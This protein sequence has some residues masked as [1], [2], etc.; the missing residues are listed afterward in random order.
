MSDRDDES[1]MPADAD[2]AGEPADESAAQNPPA[3]PEP[4]A[5]AARR[6][7]EVEKE[8]DEYLDLARRARADYMNLQRR[9]ESQGRAIRDAAQYEFAKDVIVVLDDIE[10]AMKHTREGQ[11]CSAILEGLELVKRKFVAVLAKYG[12]EPMESEG[13]PFDH[14]LHHAIAEHP[15]DDAA[16]GTVF[17]V[18]QRGYTAGG[19]L[20][21]PAHVIVT[22]RA[23]EPA[24]KPDDESDED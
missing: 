8:R 7:A 19:K 3:V 5:E 9:M 10:N 22:R 14:N 21:R 18:A 20:L 16:P 23:S 11:D 2:A 15:T 17:A 13:A 1:R 4:E 24:G 12:I 6:L